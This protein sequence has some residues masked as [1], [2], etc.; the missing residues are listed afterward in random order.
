[1]GRNSGQFLKSN[2][3][4]FFEKLPLF[5]IYIK[6]YG[7]ENFIS[8]IIKSISR[9]KDFKEKTSDFILADIEVSVL[10][11][12]GGGNFHVSAGTGSF[13]TLNSPRNGGKFL[14]FA[15][16]MGP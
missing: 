1:M 2:Y 7:N 13:L 11:S 15:V 16:E 9:E 5:K 4:L 14:N 12:G 8:A 10:M 3:P 6:T